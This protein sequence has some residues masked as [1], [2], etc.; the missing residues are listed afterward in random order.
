MLASA[1]EAVA[2]A[3]E[4]AAGAT[5]SA[6][7]TETGRWKRIAAASETLAAATTVANASLFGY[8]KRA[9]VALESIAGTD[10]TAE[11][12]NYYGYMKRTVD[13]L[14]VQGEVGVGSW[15]HRLVLA[16]EGATFGPPFADL[17]LDNSTIAEGTGPDQPVGTVLG[18]LGVGYSVSLLEQ[19][20][21]DWFA[22]D[23]D[24][25][26]AGNE[27]TDFE[28][29]PSP[30]ITMREYEDTESDFMNPVGPYHD[31]ILTITVTDVAEAPE[32][33]PDPGIGT[34]ANFQNTG[35][36]GTFSAAGGKIALSCVSKT[37]QFTATNGAHSAMLAALTNATVYDVVIE[38]GGY[39]SVAGGVFRL[40]GG[41][42]A[43]Y[44]LTGITGNGTWSF[45]VTSGT[46]SNAFLS[47]QLSSVTAVFDILSISVKL[48]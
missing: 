24:L 31:T 21:A 17:T 14:E 7:P 25:I 48:H 20:E 6:N 34:E 37:I 44:N 5:T 36:T 4:T 47:W 1:L 19:E 2:D 32:L 29:N 46:S 23:G 41:D 18:R 43:A 16:A 11:N 33:F 39:V 8:M 27:P 26:L 42:G 45:Q 12:S 3:L 35:G 28:T 13:A 38:V 10:G 22:F 40:K 30:T 15:E 9:A